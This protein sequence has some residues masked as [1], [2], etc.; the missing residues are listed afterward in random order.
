MG[1]GALT[2]LG[3]M[4]EPAMGSPCEGSYTIDGSS[5]PVMSPRPRLAATWEQDM[6]FDMTPPLPRNWDVPQVALERVP[7]P[8]A[9][10]DLDDVMWYRPVEDLEPGH[11][12]RFVGLEFTVSASVADAP[13]FGA[14]L[15]LWFEPPED[16]AKL[17]AHGGRWWI[18][19]PSYP[20]AFVH[21][22]VLVEVSGAKGRVVR[23]LVAPVLTAPDGSFQLELW[24]LARPLR[25]EPGPLCVWVAPVDDD[26]QVGSF[27]DAGCTDPN[28]RPLPARGA[29]DEGCTHV[30]GSSSGATTT[31]FLLL[32]IGFGRVRT[33]RRARSK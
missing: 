5:S 7:A 12:Y 13:A 21:H 16:Q 24:P 29:E 19:D 30:D 26:G 28:L 15:G 3:V 27:A 1:L 25:Q 10:A 2:A 32:M 17:C 8:E 9:L 22:R 4:P 6:L 33:R 20:N 18:V 23:R 14:D 31:L 11:R